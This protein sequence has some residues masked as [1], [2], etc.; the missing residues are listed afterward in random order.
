MDQEGNAN[1]VL[2]PEKGWSGGARFKS[3]EVPIYWDWDFGGRARPLWRGRL[4]GGLY[5]AASAFGVGIS[6]SVSGVGSTARGVPT[7]GAGRMA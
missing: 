4:D 1:T 3:H 6:A 2:H 5:Y 7:T